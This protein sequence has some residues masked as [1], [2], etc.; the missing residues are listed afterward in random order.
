MRNSIGAIDG[1][2]EDLF[3]IL[4]LIHKK[5]L[6]IDLESVNGHISHPHFAIMQVFGQL[7][8]L[9]VSQNISSCG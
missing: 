2:V 5:L 7:E 6:K 3:H 8:P 4:P 1:V 9:P